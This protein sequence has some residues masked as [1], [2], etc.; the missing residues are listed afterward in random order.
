M[1]AHIGLRKRTFANLYDLAGVYRSADMSKGESLFCL[2]Q[3]L[4]V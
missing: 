2:T 1:K 4:P 3:H